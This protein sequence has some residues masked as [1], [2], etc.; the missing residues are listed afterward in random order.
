MLTCTDARDGAQAIDLALK[1]EY[2]GHHQ[3]LIA[4]SDTCMRTSNDELVKRCFPNVKYTPTKGNYD[5]LLSIDKARNELG[6]VPQYTWQDEVKKL[7]P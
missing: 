4:A 2:T 3:Y 5:T 7:S 6:Y 1:K